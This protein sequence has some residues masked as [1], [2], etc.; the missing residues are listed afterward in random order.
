MYLYRR[1]MVGLDFT[2]MDKALLEYTSFLTTLVKPEKIYFVNAQE[3]LEDP[4]ELLAEYPELDGPLDEKLRDE[5][6]TAVD[7]YF[8]P[9]T[10][11][12]TE[13]LILEGNASEELHDHI[14]IKQ[15][16]LLI[17]GRKQNLKGMGIVPQKLARKIPAS[18]LFIPENAVP[19]LT[20]LV[21]PIDYSNN[22][23]I[24]LEEASTLAS[25]DPHEN[26]IV[27]LHSYSLPTGYYK[28][29][30]SEEEFAEVM[31]ANSKKKQHALLTDI[32][33]KGNVIREEYV[34]DNE[35]T[36][37]EVIN[38]FAHKVNANLIVIG[39]KGRTDASALFL[40]STAEK[41]IRVDNDI[42]L[43][44]VKDKQ[45]TF[46]LLEMLKRL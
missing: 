3:G 33:L 45:A 22:S 39:G 17:V 1:I 15:I 25:N 6:Q 19:S 31:L 44:V 4:E 2:P 9:N 37:A 10:G 40:G 11:T 21:V 38:E 32:D 43:L 29:G 8:N 23:K 26:Q 16:D 12:Q 36:T 41:L 7:Q 13:C 35:H 24:A 42:P 30:K 14:Q 18:L 27:T 20:T 34:F 28:T 5:I 46:G